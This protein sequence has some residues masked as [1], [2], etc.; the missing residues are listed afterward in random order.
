MANLQIN[1]RINSTRKFHVEARKLDFSVE[2][3]KHSSPKSLRTDGT[4]SSLWWSHT[5]E[6]PCIVIVDALWRS[7]SFSP[8]KDCPALEQDCPPFEEQSSEMD[9]WNSCTG[10]LPIDMKPF[11][12]SQVVQTKVAQ[13][14]TPYWMRGLADSAYKAESDHQNIEKLQLL[15]YNAHSFINIWIY[16]MW[17]TINLRAHCVGQHKKLT[18]IKIYFYANRNLHFVSRVIFGLFI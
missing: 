11:M 17:T 4:I 9:W 7:G 8:V 10:I 6:L 3:E 1:L 16:E 13:A 15:P 14:Q 5:L 2:E 18:P 12:P